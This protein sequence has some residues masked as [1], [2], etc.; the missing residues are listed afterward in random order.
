MDY[1]VF[2]IGV[3]ATLVLIGWLVREYGAAMRYRASNLDDAPVRTAEELVAQMAWQRFSRAVGTIV[4]SCGG[5]LIIVTAGTAATTPEDVTASIIVGAMFVAIIIG[6][7]VWTGL[8]I[9]RFGTHG[10]IRPRVVMREPAAQTVDARPE[11]SP[12]VAPATAEAPPEDAV[13]GPPLPVP[14]SSVNVG[15]REL[16]DA[17]DA[18]VATTGTGSEPSDEVDEDGEGAAALSAITSSPSTTRSLEDLLNLPPNQRQH[19]DDPAFGAGLVSVATLDAQTDEEESV[20]RGDEA[21]ANLVEGTEPTVAADT[22]GAQATREQA[23][24]N[25]RRRRIE[26]QR[27]VGTDDD[28]ES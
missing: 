10:I 14:A 9:K 17:A 2:G 22:E 8:Y 13:Y 18:G 20:H 11:Q 5:L 15:A 19:A 27:T 16:D 4:A 25:L 26:R 23:L 21:T 7:G 1:I 28:G 6:V 3:G 24:A 12:G